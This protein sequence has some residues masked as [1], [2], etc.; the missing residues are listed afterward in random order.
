M[1]EKILVVDDSL[2]IQK[3]I[4]ITLA[5]QRYNL[6]ECH[7]ENELI[8]MLQTD[9]FHLVLLDFTISENKTGY[10]LAE[11][12]KQ[13]RPGCSIMA[14]LGTFDPVDEQGLTE[15]GIDDYIVKPFE[16]EKLIVKCRELAD[17]ANPGELGEVEEIQDLNKEPN[18]NDDETGVFNLDEFNDVEEEEENVDEWVLESAAKTEEKPKE[19]VAPIE[20][21][22]SNPLNDELEGWGIDVPGSIGEDA[23]PQEIIPPQISKPAEEIIIPEENDLD[24]PELNIDAGP[25]QPQLVSTESFDLEEEEEKVEDETDPI[26]NLDAVSDNL[27]KAVQDEVDADSFWALD[28][29]EQPQSPIEE[30]EED[31]PSLKMEDEEEV[32]P[33]QEVDQDKLVNDLKTA[34]LPIMEQLVKD[35]CK[36]N[37]EQVAWEVIPDLAENLIRNELEEIAKSVIKE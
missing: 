2:T 32:T 14:M 16:S 19:D 33:V 34:M 20:D 36:Q 18:N 5:S 24:Y 27:E 15:A 3:V 29:G 10:A 11:E 22:N 31:L 35:Y 13:V 4:S 8:T 17:K 9:E 37:I 23:E 6:V 12:I 28:D 26:I 21:I 30:I 25:R 7:N 1:S